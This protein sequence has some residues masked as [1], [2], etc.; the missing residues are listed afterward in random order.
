MSTPITVAF[1]DGIG[2]E[3]MEAT[4][5]ILREAGAQ[6]SVETIEIGKRIYDMESNSGI[7]PSSYSTLRHNKILLKA[8][9]FKP[10]AGDFED[11]TIAICKKFNLDDASKKIE[12]CD[13]AADISA[14]AY[15]NEYFSIFEP[16][17]DETTAKIK[18]RNRANPSATILASIMMLEH[19]GQQEV[20]TRIRDAWRKTI[21]EG[22]HT[23]DMYKRGTST[24]KAGTRQFAE[25]IVERLYK[26]QYRAM[27]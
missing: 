14:A 3:I 13:F 19:I 27:G 11:V 10:E 24:K 26:T 15:I 21:E 4:L 1:G 18:S 16:V 7:L 25:A 12:H 5:H 20:A 23:R 17:I 6:I 8:P 2:P 9:T 22:I